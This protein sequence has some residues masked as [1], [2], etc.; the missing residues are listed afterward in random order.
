MMHLYISKFLSLFETEQLVEELTNFEIDT[1]NIVVHQPMFTKNVRE[2]QPV[3]PL[4]SP[5][6]TAHCVWQKMQQ[7]DP[8]EIR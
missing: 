2:T 5:T 6:E 3:S 1:D 8:A 4:A 7:K